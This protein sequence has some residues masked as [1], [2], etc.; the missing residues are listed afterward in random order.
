MNLPNKTP[1]K[2]QIKHWSVFCTKKISYNEGLV[3]EISSTVLNSL[4]IVKF[5][6]LCCRFSFPSTFYYVSFNF[7]LFFK[8]TSMKSRVKGKKRSIFLGDRGTLM[9]NNEQAK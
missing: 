4:P 7:S 2:R 8:K 3:F 1:N 5:N 6:V 9:K